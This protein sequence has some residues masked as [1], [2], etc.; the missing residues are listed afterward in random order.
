MADSHI[1]RIEKL[2]DPTHVRALPA[3]DFARLFADAGLAT[4]HEVGSTLDYDLEA[5]IAHGAPGASARDEIVS[6]MESCLESDR[7]GLR[8]RREDA[9]IR[10]SHRAAAYVLGR[11]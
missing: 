3:S 4:V 11:P 2:C 5:W 9:H 6:L 10:F 1:D 7:A 8:V